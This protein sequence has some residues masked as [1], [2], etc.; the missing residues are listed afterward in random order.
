MAS[1]E[2]VAAAA[3]RA[4]RPGPPQPRLA[5][6]LH[7]PHGAQRACALASLRRALVRRNSELPPRTHSATARCAAQL[8][9]L[10][11]R[12][13]PPRS[14]RSTVDPPPMRRHVAES[15]TAPRPLE[16]LHKS[17]WLYSKLTRD[18]A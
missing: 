10:P 4:T 13:P 5:R 12:P 1:P 2:R 6:A 11:Q 14:A 16:I 8:A 18:P 17:P 15:A 9:T 7:P 3:A